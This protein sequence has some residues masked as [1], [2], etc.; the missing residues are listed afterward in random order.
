MRN[1]IFLKE[2]GSKIKAERLA[3]KHSLRELGLLVG[4][5][6]TSLWFIENGRKDIHILN[7]K[8]IADAYKKDV[9]DFL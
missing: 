3:N 2:M 5:H 8:K 4:L 1:D 9:K 6:L 7:L